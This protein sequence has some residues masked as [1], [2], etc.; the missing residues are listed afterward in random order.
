VTAPAVATIDEYVA[1]FP[2]EVQTILENIRRTVQETVPEAVEAISYRM[3]TF[4]LGDRKIVHFAAYK[5]HIG[6]YPAPA[7]PEEFEAE[8]AP[9]RAATATIRF[10]IAEPVPLHLVRRI[11]ELLVA[12]NGQS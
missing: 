11:V 12:E 2:P 8:I 6:F 5:H 10:P 3:P 7:G 1:T 9:Y 4:K